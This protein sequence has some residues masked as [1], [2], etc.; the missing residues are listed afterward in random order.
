M[1][2][3]SQILQATPGRSACAGSGA[4]GTGRRSRSCPRASRSGF[5]CARSATS[6]DK[7]TL[8]FHHST[9]LWLSETGTRRPPGGAA[10]PGRTRPG[11]GSFS[12]ATSLPACLPINS[13][14]F[15]G[16][17]PGELRAALQL[18]G[19]GIALRAAGLSDNGHDRGRCAAGS[20]LMSAMLASTRSSSASRSFRSR[21]R[22]SSNV[23][24]LMAVVTWCPPG[25]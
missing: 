7:I 18:H 22:R 5:R 16:E 12:T 8:H 19:G 10:G 1:M 17:D 4:T 23:T 15:D 11:R 21:R 24:V 14:A 9:F 3:R 25:R 2:L 13:C 6:F 20:V